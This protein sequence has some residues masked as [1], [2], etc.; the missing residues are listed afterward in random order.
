MS[1]DHDRLFKE[2][3][4]TFFREFMEAFFPEVH[5]YLDCSYL[6]FLPQEVFTDVPAG[7]KYFVDI[8]ARTRV[9]GILKI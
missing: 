3:I 4:T 6:E 9:A 2:L 8:L 7:E 1:V 5:H